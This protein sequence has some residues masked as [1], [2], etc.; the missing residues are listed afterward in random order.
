M[1]D[2]S[3]IAV[4]HQHIPQPTPR[5]SELVMHVLAEYRHLVR[6]IPPDQSANLVCF[7]GGREFDVYSIGKFGDILSIAGKTEDGTTEFKTYAPVELVSFTIILGK[8]V[9][10]GPPPREIGFSAEMKQRGAKS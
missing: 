2:L 8:K 4:M 6:T 5:G 7:V 3:K 9:K 1:N 10:A